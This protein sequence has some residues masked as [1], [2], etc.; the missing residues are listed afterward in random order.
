MLESGT[1]WLKIM[2]LQVTDAF[3]R[4]PSAR[5]RI[6]EGGWLALTGEASADMNMGAVLDTDQAGELLEIYCDELGQLPAVV[7]LEH[8]TDALV[9]QANSRGAKAVGEVPIMVWHGDTVPHFDVDE[10]IEVGPTLAPGETNA[11]IGV[12]AEAFSLDPAM[13]RRALGAMAGN[14]ITRFWIGE[15]EGEIVGAAMT[16]ITGGIVGI[17]CMATPERLQH[18]GIGRA[19]L[20]TL[21]TQHAQS[22]TSTAPVRFLLGATPAGRHLYDEVEF[23]VV[24]SPAALAF[25]VSTQFDTAPQ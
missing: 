1:F 17:Y 24:A 8:A 10:S 21:M 2:G 11:A 25:G 15:R 4:S 7:M 19:V 5:A 3:G 14:P 12:I 6:D 18:Q 22:A 20:C 23:E 13:C 9:A 16:L